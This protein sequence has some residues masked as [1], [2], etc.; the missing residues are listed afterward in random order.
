LELPHRVRRNFSVFWVTAYEAS[1]LDAAPEKLDP[2]PTRPTGKRTRLRLMTSNFCR[3]SVSSQASLR[4]VEPA[5]SL[6]IDDS[7]RY[8]AKKAFPLQS[9]AISP[10]KIA[11]RFSINQR[12]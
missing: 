12:H 1:A 3:P 10:K 5:I 9:L 6:A 7:S 2:P 4:H 11:C 8:H